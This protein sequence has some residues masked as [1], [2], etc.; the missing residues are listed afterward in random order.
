LVADAVAERVIHFLEAVEVEE[1]DHH[2]PGRGLKRLQI[3][4]RL[5]ERRTIHEVRQRVA[6]KL[7]LQGRQMRLCKRGLRSGPARCEGEV[8]CGP[9]R[10]DC[11]DEVDPR[12]QVKRAASR[13]HETDDAKKNGGKSSDRRGASL[14]R[15]SRQ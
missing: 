12:R 5:V 2:Q 1:Q 10:C 11:G 6:F 14:A 3:V 9:Y 13:C 7:L 8:A 15:V 4:E